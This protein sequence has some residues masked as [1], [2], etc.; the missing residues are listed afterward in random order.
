MNFSNRHLLL[1]AKAAIFVLMAWLIADRLFLQNDIDNQWQLFT[2]HINGERFYLFIIAILFMPLNWVLETVKW[3][4]L[5]QSSYAPFKE[6]M[7]GVIA[8]VT[9]G[10][11]TP[12]RSGEFIGRVLY[13]NEQDKTKVFYLTGIGGIAQTAV[14]LLVGSLCLNVLVD[15]V[16]IQGI[17]M[18]LALICTLFYFRFDL[19]NRLI[20]SFPFLVRKGL[21]IHNTEIPSTNLLLKVFG[22]SAAR[23]GVYL[24]QYVAVFMFFGVSTNALLLTAHNAVLL[25]VQSFSPLLPFMDISFRGGSALWVYGNISQNN[26]AI[27]TA[28]LSIWVIN[29]VL[30]AVIG[31]VFIV[32]KK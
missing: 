20:N 26:I 22:I 32:R 28:A 31:Y 8:G 30:P 10:F 12:G 4:I 13:L 18:G 17:A 2:Q 5:L 16:F 11:V 1:A 24:L 15:D 14:T 29:L 3:R 23:Y 6:L 9:F 27:L 7:K 25:L 21:T 19:L